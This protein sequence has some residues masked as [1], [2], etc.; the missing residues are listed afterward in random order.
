MYNVRWIAMTVLCLYCLTKYSTIF[1]IIYVMLNHITYIVAEYD[2]QYICECRFVGAFVCIKNNNHFESII[3][4]EKI[5]F[6]C[7][8]AFINLKMFL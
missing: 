6:K 4:Q 8:F 2:K 5:N 7:Y 3:S 1:W